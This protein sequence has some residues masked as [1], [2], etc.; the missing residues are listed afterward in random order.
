[1]TFEKRFAII[2]GVVRSARNTN[3]SKRRQLWGISS[4]GRALACHARGHRF[5][6]GIL[7]HKDLSEKSDR[8]FFSFK[9]AE[10]SKPVDQPLGN[11]GDEQHKKQCAKPRDKAGCVAADVPPQREGEQQKPGHGK[12]V[13]QKRG[14]LP[15]AEHPPDLNGL[16]GAALRRRMV[17]AAAVHADK[18]QMLRLQ[19][20]KAAHKDPD[21]INDDPNDHPGTPAAP[22]GNTSQY[23]LCLYHSTLKTHLQR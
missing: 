3:A 17:P 11:G 16:I 18:A 4:A 23:R 15:A 21:E 20:D 1:M 7:H 14:K 5:D 22:V 19:L 9:H 8:S 2:N 12:A 13:Q 10:K 6:P